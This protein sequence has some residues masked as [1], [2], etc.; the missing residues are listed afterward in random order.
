M[1]QRRPQGW[2]LNKGKIIVS[3]TV[4]T[5][6]DRTSYDRSYWI[7]SSVDIL[8]LNKFFKLGEVGGRGWRQVDKMPGHG[9][10]ETV[11]A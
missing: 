1:N 3:H 6:E 4:R 10:V 8:N 9:P 7:K 2:R 5:L 11:T